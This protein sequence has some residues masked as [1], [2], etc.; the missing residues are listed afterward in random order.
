MGASGSKLASNIYKLCCGDSEDFCFDVRVEA[1][2]DFQ[3]HLFETLRI[4]NTQKLNWACCPVGISGAFALCAVGA[5]YNTRQQIVDVLDP[6]LRVE[7]VTKRIATDI[8]QKYITTYDTLYKKY[9][10]RMMLGGFGHGA[11]YAGADDRPLLLIVTRIVCNPQLSITRPVDYFADPSREY[12]PW[13]TLSSRHCDQFLGTDSANDVNKEISGWAEGRIA[14]MVTAD[15]MPNK[16]ALLVC[17]GSYFSGFFA[18]PFSERDTRE[19]VTFFADVGRTKKRSTVSMMHSV[20]VQSVAK[21]VKGA[22]DMVKLEYRYRESSVLSLVVAMNTGA[23]NA[24]L[25]TDDVFV[26]D[27][28][29]RKCSLFLPK[30]AFS[31]DIDL[32]AVM[33]SMGVTDVFDEKL[34]D[35]ND[36]YNNSHSGFRETYVPSHLCVGDAIHMAR[37]EV[38]DED[39][40]R[41]EDEADAAVNAVCVRFDIPFRFYVVDEEQKAVLFYGCF[42]GRSDLFR[43][44]MLIE[45]YLK[46]FTAAKIIPSTIIHLVCKW[47][48][49]PQPT[50][51]EPSCYD[52]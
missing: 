43:D 4:R 31:H 38:N 34:A 10:P 51:R 9:G 50:R 21:A 20:G 15:M 12:D 18:I 46:K 11:F 26:V 52:A 29:R 32:K 7:R 47:Y 42:E 14:D 49:T 28:S 37:I 2:N 40:E 25:C 27:W 19:F 45:G 3:T 41:N 35:L 16:D 5:R 24:L 44:S 30:F 13:P 1:K 48:C 33:K 22:W 23:T 39:T 36:L 8:A 17:S 6:S